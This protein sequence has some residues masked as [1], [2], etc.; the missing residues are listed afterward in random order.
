MTPSMGWGTQ[1]G[2]GGWGMPSAGGQAAPSYGTPGLAMG[3]GGPIVSDPQQNQPPQT[4]SAWGGVPRGVPAWGMPQSQD[5]QQYHS[6]GG[7][8]YQPPMQQF[9]PPNG[10]QQYQPMPM[11]GFGIGQG[12]QGSPWGM[13]MGGPGMQQDPRMAMLNRF[14]MMQQAQRM[15]GGNGMGFQRPQPQTQPQQ[16]S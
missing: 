5:G 12:Q 4:A 1:R 9:Q 10:G 11:R 3:M 14:R 16:L 7:Q 15:G 6:N 13:R 2:P 8:Q